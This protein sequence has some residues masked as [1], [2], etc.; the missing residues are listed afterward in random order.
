[1]PT[2][3]EKPTK[4]A[5]TGDK[6]G[7]GNAGQQAIG[8]RDTD[9][10]SHLELRSFGRRRGR[11]L[12]PRQQ[13]L[14]RDRLPGLSVDTAAA[15]PTPLGEL[16]APPVRDVWLEIGFGGA[17]HLLCQARQYPEVGFIGC[18]P[19][20]D[21]VA[22][23]LIGIEEGGLSNVRLHADDARDV[24]RWLPEAGLGRAFILF[25][26][27]WPKKRHL[28]RRLINSELVS[29][30]ARVLRPGAE[31][32]IATDIEDYLRTILM[33]LLPSSQ[34]QWRCKAADDWRRRCEDWPGTRY[35]AKALR[36]GR[37]C[38]YLTFERT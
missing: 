23:A 8:V 9:G 25:P 4:R 21:G 7:S 12:S 28:K 15:P 20:E 2:S 24:L 11:V 38:T 19:F 1:M 35:E 13:A 36:E 34:F 5:L 6:A 33:A 17:E 37:K 10:G 26:D 14:M 16:F 27:P 18:E 32:R 31:L 22:K 30:L 29:A 3:N